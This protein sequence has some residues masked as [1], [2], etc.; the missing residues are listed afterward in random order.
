MFLDEDPKP[1]SGFYAGR[2]VKLDEYRVTPYLASDY[3]AGRE[4]PQP[5]LKLRALIASCR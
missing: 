1:K 5:A 2:D 3:Y 4:K